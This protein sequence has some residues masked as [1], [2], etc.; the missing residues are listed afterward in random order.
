MRTRIWI[1][2]M[3]VYPLIGFIGLGHHPLIQNP[4]DV[5][6]VQTD[7]KLGVIRG[8][9]FT[10]DGGHPLSKVT[11]TL[12]SSSA[13]PQDRP[14]TARTNSRGTYEFTNL[15]GGTYVLRAT[16]NG[17][18]PR[19]YGQKTPYAFGRQGAGT[20]LSIRSREVLEGVDF[21]L[22]RGGVVEGRVVDQDN[23]PISRVSVRM[24]G[25]RILGGA[26][27]LLP[28]GRDQTDDRGQFRIFDLPPGSYYLSASQRPATD[29]G[30]S[31]IAS[32]P[33]TYYPGVQSIEEATTVQVAAGAEVAGFDL[34]LIE[35]RS[36]SVGGRV[37]APDGRPAHSAWIVSTKDSGND[38][39]SMIGPTTNTNL[40]GEFTISGLLPGRHRLFARSGEGDEKQIA[41]TTVDV[42]DHDLS[43]LTLILGTGAEVSGRIVAD[44]LNSNLDW[45]RILLSMRS[46]RNVNLLFSSARGGQVEE[47]FTFRISDL[48]EGLYR[49]SVRLPPG[50][51]YVE[52]VRVEGQEIIDRSIET[53]N[54]DRLEGVEIH[55]SSEGAQVSGVVEQEDTQERADGA[56]VLVFAA[57][58]Q[59]RGRYSRFTRTTQTDQ[60]GRFSLNGL[61]PAEYFLCALV[62]HEAGREMEL[63]YLRSLERDSESIDLSPNQIL[64]QNLVAIPTPNIF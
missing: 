36:Y 52:S 62:D 40:Q 45:R 53:K 2:G 22:I 18:I 38:I 57:D 28:I 10:D 25:Y 20:A 5:D 17:Y 44:N 35:I 32:F 16:R 47:D 41:S 58:A 3:A 60:S 61:V 13:R 51:H 6:R 8:R 23:D 48:P 21:N 54:N 29:Q 15:D 31:E 43:G 59:F 12:R 56:T 34:T 46:V 64:E 39:G 4:G 50:N 24:S 11:L 42:A 30:R 33:P 9:V 63:E 55:V 26:R 19:Y 37:L 7:E 1:V 27:R 49:F 14:Q